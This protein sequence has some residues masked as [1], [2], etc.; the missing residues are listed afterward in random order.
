MVGS[1]EVHGSGNSIRYR[2]R[3]SH[4]LSV[5]MSLNVTQ[6]PVAV[7]VALIPHIE[8]SCRLKVKSSIV[9][10]TALSYMNSPHYNLSN[11]ELGRFANNPLAYSLVTHEYLI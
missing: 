11:R 9:L 3:A 4:A 8:K 5:F 2:L 1:E 7:Q 6:V 10:N